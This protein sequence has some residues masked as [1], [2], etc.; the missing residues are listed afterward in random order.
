MK[1]Q[2]KAS[3][4]V[5]AALFAGSILA[6]PASAANAER[7]APPPLPPTAT[8]PDVRKVTPPGRA[9]APQECAAAAEGEAVTCVKPLKKQLK[10]ATGKQQ[11]L[12]P[13]TV[14]PLP[15]W[16]AQAGTL[17]EGYYSATR[18]EACGNWAYQLTV[19]RKVK[20]SQTVTGVMEFTLSG[21]H[22][23]AQNQPTVAHQ[24]TI[25][26]SSMTGDAVGA[27][28][29]ATA[30]CWQN[31]AA[32]SQGFG[33]QTLTTG[34]G[35]SGEFFYNTTAITPGA[36]G[37]TGS[38]WNITF[39]VPSASNS[40]TLGSSSLNV[41]CDTAL[42]N[43]ASTGCV[44]PDIAPYIQ[45]QGFDSFGT[46]VKAAQDSGLPGA[47]SGAPLHR[48]VNQTLRDLNRNTACPQNSSYPRPTGYS[49]DEYPFASTSEGAYT[50]GGTAR[51]FPWCQITLSAPDSTGPVGYSVCMINLDE[52]NYAGS[53]LNNVLYAPMR[54]IDADPF[55]VHI[56]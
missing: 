21:F 12:T 19:V 30:Q 24:I 47:L 26:P 33:T 2:S 36:V 7:P 18:Y 31:C 17:P 9:Q 50:G 53:V 1:R 39:K 34:N 49:C 56:A 54:V 27:T 25:I 20:G 45:Y 35:S 13:M 44:N 8:A 32:G 3:L 6:G 10:P 23:G 22:Y 43:N 55:Y 37:P 46:H 5:C 16:C 42:P 40:W 48:L 28:A 41:R 38:S 52:N 29:S 15:S 14:Q 4:A 51:T 11:A